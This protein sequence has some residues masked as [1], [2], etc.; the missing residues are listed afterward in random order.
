VELWRST[1]AATSFSAV[2]LLFLPRHRDIALD[3]PK[4]WCYRA[5]L[6]GRNL[7]RLLYLDEAGTDQH[8]P[9]LTVAGVLVHGDC[10]WPEIDQRI[11]ALIEKYIPPSDRVNFVFHATDIF[12]GSDYFDRRKPEWPEHRRLALLNE[13]ANIIDELSLPVVFGTYEKEKFGVGTI[14]A[15]DTHQKKARLIHDV[16]VIDCLMRADK[17]LA[18]F[19]PTEL[20]TVVHED[21]TSAKSTIKLSVRFARSEDHIKAQGFDPKALELPLRRIIDTV[22][23]AEKA[24]ARPLQLADLCAFILARGFKNKPVPER[25]TEIIFKHLRWIMNYDQNFSHSTLICP[26]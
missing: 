16:A 15:A 23:F 2:H 26:E 21:G 22:H 12:H 25:P 8:A 10:E 19:A 18:L 20:A 1:F 9:W 4:G 24:D 17:W 7:V 5:P 14:P 3:G 11:A 13:L 6:L